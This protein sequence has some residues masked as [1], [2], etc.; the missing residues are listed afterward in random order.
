MNNF[1]EIDIN[2]LKQ[3]LDYDP[4]TGII[5]WK[6]RPLSFFKEEKYRKSWNTRWAGKEAGN[7]TKAGPTIYKNKIIQILSHNYKTHRVVWAL[8]FGEWPDGYIDHINGDALDNRICNL[9]VTNMFNNTRNSPRRCDNTSG[10]TGVTFCK[11]LK[12]WRADINTADGKTKYLGRYKDIEDAVA[13]RKKAEIKYGYHEN[14]GRDN[15]NGI[16]EEDEDA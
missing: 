11:E 5:T 16:R 8:H 13:A 10:Y 12:R 15:P 14:H 9:R 2:I 3:L 6:E 7:V 4:D 1:I